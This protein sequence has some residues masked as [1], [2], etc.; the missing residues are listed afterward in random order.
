MLISFNFMS[1]LDQFKTLP[2]LCRQSLLFLHGFKHFN[3]INEW[4]F[5]QLAVHVNIIIFKLKGLGHDM[6][7]YLAIDFRGRA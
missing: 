5:L 7:Y 6:F 2:L 3:P 1:K 4:K